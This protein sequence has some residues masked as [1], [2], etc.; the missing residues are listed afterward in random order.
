MKS[1]IRFS[2]S[3]VVVRV[4][5]VISGNFVDFGPYGFME[6]ETLMRDYDKCRQMYLEATK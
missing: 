3:G 6:A 4:T 5:D 1:E 2:E